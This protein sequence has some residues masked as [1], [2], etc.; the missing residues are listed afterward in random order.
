MSR[1][2]E[3]IDELRAEYTNLVKDI[4]DAKD[5]PGNLAEARSAMTRFMNNMTRQYGFDIFVDL[6]ADPNL[7]R[8]TTR[9]RVPPPPPGSIE[10]SPSASGSIGDRGPVQRTFAADGPA[11][12]IPDDF[13]DDT[14]D[15][16]IVGSGYTPTGNA[17]LQLAHQ[18]RAEAKMS[19]AG[20]T[21]SRVVPLRDMSDR[22][23]RV[24]AYL[25]SRPAFR[26]LRFPE[27]EVMVQQVLDAMERRERREARSQRRQAIAQNSNVGIAY[28]DPNNP[29]SLYLVDPSN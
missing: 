15:E 13:F 5:S 17:L 26:I 8:L 18:M 11:P 7:R 25:Q 6:N 14:D 27:R 4:E 21:Q 12:P 16:T 2:P 20:A 29:G 24:R 19:G 23:I 28:Q 1:R 10:S 22:E 3:N 9:A